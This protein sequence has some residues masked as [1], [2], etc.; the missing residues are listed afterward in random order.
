MAVR[1]QVDLGRIT[2]PSS[3]ELA[4]L[5]GE[6]DGT[7]EEYISKEQDAYNKMVKYG[8]DLKERVGDAADL[9]VEDPGEV[10][11]FSD[12]ESKQVINLPTDTSEMRGVLTLENIGN[13]DELIT[14]DKTIV[15]A[16]NELYRLI[17]STGN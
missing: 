12:E 11:D 9:Y 7:L 14:S 8:E 13:P 1:K 2:G 15:G 17:T 10:K 5:M 16:I 4:V 6:F 3:Y